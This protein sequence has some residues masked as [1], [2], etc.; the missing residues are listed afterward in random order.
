M[1]ATQKCNFKSELF[2]PVIRFYIRPNVGLYVRFS[3]SHIWP[4]FS[5]HLCGTFRRE[6]YGAVRG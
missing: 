1:T 6:Q 2:E 5:I 4:I 3:G